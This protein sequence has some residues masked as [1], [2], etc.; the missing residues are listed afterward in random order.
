MMHCCLGHRR[1]C[2]SIA[3]LCFYSLLQMFLNC[4]IIWTV[5]R[6]KLSPLLAVFIAKS[7]ITMIFFLGDLRHP[8]QFRL[9]AEI[10][11][12]VCTTSWW[13]RFMKE[14]HL[15]T[16][17]Y[18]FDGKHTQISGFSNETMEFYVPAFLCFQTGVKDVTSSYSEQNRFLKQTLDIFMMSVKFY[19]WPWGE[20][21]L[22]CP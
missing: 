11:V 10:C 21:R 14:K 15:Y 1:P 16:W 4:L 7:F 9:W 20:V 5:Q 2:V 13:M 12:H 22:T 18:T 19:I 8:S 3:D 17:F 6:E